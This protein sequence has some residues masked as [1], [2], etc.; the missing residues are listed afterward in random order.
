MINKELQD[1]LK[2][3]PDNM[4][5]GMTADSNAFMDEVD[6]KITKLFDEDTLEPVE[7]FICLG[8]LT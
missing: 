1:K 8:D 2:Q 3:F 4:K 5:V 7:D 6:P